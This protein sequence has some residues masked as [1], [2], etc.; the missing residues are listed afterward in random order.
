MEYSRSAAIE[1]NAEVAVKDVDFDKWDK[2]GKDCLKDKKTCFEKIQ[3]AK[4]PKIAITWKYDFH[5]TTS[6]N[7]CITR[8]SSQSEQNSVAQRLRWSAIPAAMKVS[9]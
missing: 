8:L 3:S 2:M 1:A 9:K 7:D 6:A 5:A 4:L